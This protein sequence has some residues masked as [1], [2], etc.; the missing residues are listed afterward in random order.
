M[1]LLLLELHSQIKCI[2]IS[3]TRSMNT[4]TKQNK[5]KQKKVLFWP[6]SGLQQN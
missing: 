6:K 2:A 5:E 1:P 3:A 4:D